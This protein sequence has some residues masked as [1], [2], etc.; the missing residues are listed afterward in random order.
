MVIK[1]FLGEESVDDK[2]STSAIHLSSG[3]TMTSQNMEYG[4]ISW[5][6]VQAGTE[7]EDRCAHSM[8]VMLRSHQ[9]MTS[10]LKRYLL[11]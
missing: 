5:R 11:T 4:S 2:L 9:L 10:D 3:V 6:S 1:P 8:A 7:H